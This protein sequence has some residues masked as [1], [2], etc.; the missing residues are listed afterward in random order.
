ME[1]PKKYA[2]LLSE[3]NLDVYVHFILFSPGGCCNSCAVAAC[4]LQ[5]QLHIEQ[6]QT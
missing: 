2:D 5:C 6:S 4:T 1:S 3:R